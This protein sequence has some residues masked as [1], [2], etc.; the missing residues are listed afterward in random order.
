MTH[1][2]HYRARVARSHDPRS[3][4]VL[5]G[6]RGY[7]LL[8][9]LLMSALLVIGVAIVVPTITFEIRR[10]KEAELIHRGAQYSRA[11]R[12]FTKAT[13]RYPLRLEELQSTDGR[14]F[15]RKLYKD[16]ITGG[17]FRL[18][19]LSDVHA[20]AP[21]PTLND[22]GSQDR[23]DSAATTA[24]TNSSDATT[25]NQPAPNG[26]GN[27]A[28]GTSPQNPSQN[29][30]NSNGVPS[31]GVIMGV[32]STSKDRTVREFE[33]K[34]HYNQWLFFYDPGYD[35][36]LFITGPTSLTIPGLGTQNPS[37]AI[38][39]QPQQPQSSPNQSLQNQATNPPSSN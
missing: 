26:G 5:R 37:G 27:L 38:P 12:A 2:T 8:A 22:S 3:R 35:R 29:S 4:A 16:P 13:A 1:A 31:D 32:A 11:I 15:I 17:D 39:G 21:T 19:H 24:S 30:G 25:T 18:L 28:Q 14:R 6:Q 20:A 36:G 10:D 9:L 23:A 33:G 34:N 7:V